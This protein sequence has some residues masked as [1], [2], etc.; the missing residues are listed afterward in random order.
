MPGR[1]SRRVS[2]RHARVR[3]PHRYTAVL[4]EQLLPASSLRSDRGYPHYLAEFLCFRRIQ[5]LCDPQH[6]HDLENPAKVIDTV[7]ATRQMEVHRLTDC[8]C[9]PAVESVEIL[10]GRQA[11]GCR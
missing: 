2:T 1:A 11:L 10:P 8:P 4:A 6:I 7:Q 3:A 5:G 9:D